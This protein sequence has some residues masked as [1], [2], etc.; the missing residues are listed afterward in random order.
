MT[1][2]PKPVAYIEWVDAALVTGTWQDE[3]ASLA[4][5]EE[6]VT[7]PIRT[8]GFLLERTEGRIVV[9]TSRNAN[10]GDAAGVFVI[11]AENVRKLVVW[12]PS[13]G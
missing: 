11:P 2:E 8:A 9:A 5:A 12:D 4:E 1:F 10:N 3:A 6:F 7:G 13:A